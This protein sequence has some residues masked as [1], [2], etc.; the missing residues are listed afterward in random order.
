MA[1]YWWFE[2]LIVIKVLE[3]LNPLKEGFFFFFPLVYIKL[4]AILDEGE[5]HMVDMLP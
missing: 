2:W 1:E 3:L 5:V 4:V